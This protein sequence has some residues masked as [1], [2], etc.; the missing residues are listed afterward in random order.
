MRD[1][2]GPEVQAHDLVRRANALQ[3]EFVDTNI[4]LTNFLTRR[5]AR[6]TPPAVGYLASLNTPTPYSEAVERM[7]CEAGRARALMD[8]LIAATVVQKIGSSDE[9]FDRRW[10]ECWRFGHDTAAFHFS[11]RPR[12]GLTDD[13]PG[14]SIA[15]HSA[16]HRGPTDMAAAGS[17]DDRYATPFPGGAIDNGIAAAMNKR[18]SACRFTRR[19]VTREVLAQVLFS[20]AGV[21]GYVDDVVFGLHPLSFSPSGG[22]LNPYELYVITGRV[23]E[24]P[25]ATYHYHGIDQSL[26]RIGP[27]PDNAAALADDQQWASDAAFMTL[28][29]A[30][31]DRTWSKY[32]SP[33]GYANVLIE[34]GHRAQ[35]ALLMATDLELSARM[36]T[37]IDDDIAHRALQLVR[38]EQAPIYLL[39]FGY[40]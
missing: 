39:A 8:S 40:E 30:V 11:V 27:Y 33:A 14:G 1:D 37:A 18:R 5:S 34:A 38:S 17:A 29:V 22:A 20:M 19:A 16:A 15:S 13:R 32:P 6:L 35:N 3:L 23:L 21:T 31:L 24:I 25:P 28:L 36:T 10:A 26:Y 7:P 9:V 12:N 4:R 2:R